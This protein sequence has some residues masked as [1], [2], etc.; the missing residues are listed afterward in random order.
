[1]S[2]RLSKNKLLATSTCLGIATCGLFVASAALTVTVIM[3]HT[4]VAKLFTGESDLGVVRADASNN[5][6]D[7]NDVK[8][9]LMNNCPSVPK[10]FFKHI[11]TGFNADKTKIVVSST[12]SEY[13]GNYEFSYTKEIDLPVTTHFFDIDPNNIIVGYSMNFIS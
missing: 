3:S 10:N 1:M 12:S 9:I 5:T 11:K 4:D 13:Y 7:T 6:I 2:F 8:N